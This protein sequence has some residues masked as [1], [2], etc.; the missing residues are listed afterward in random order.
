MLKAK[1]KR[2]GTSPENEMRNKEK[3]RKEG[4]EGAGEQRGRQIGGEA[5]GN[6]VR[7]QRRAGRPARRARRAGTTCVCGRAPGARHRGGRGGEGQGASVQQTHWHERVSRRV[8]SQRPLHSPGGDFI[9]LRSVLETR[10]CTEAGEGGEEREGTEGWV[11]G[12]A[13]P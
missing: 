1:R 11:V 8:D 5:S 9:L 7:G 12:A 13:I 2:R 6:V 4:G 3:E 10:D